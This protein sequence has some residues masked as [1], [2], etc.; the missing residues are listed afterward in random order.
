MRQELAVADGNYALLRLI[1]QALG[2]RPGGAAPAVLFAAAA[3]ALW[4]AVRRAPERFAAPGVR[5]ELDAALVA[6]GASVSL[7]VAR[8]AWLHYYVLAIPAVLV[9]LRPRAGG[10]APRHLALPLLALLAL[11]G[12]PATPV[13]GENA[14]ALAALASTGVLVLFALLL[15]DLTQSG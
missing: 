10:A 12:A 5:F 14:V 3:A 1:E 8:L 4:L 2:W 6:F 7:L 15:T 13:V 9:L 11:A